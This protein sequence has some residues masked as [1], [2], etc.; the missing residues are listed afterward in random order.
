MEDVESDD[1]ARHWLD[2]S[3]PIREA[4]TTTAEEDAKLIDDHTHFLRDKVRRCYFRYYH[5]HKIIVKRGVIIEEF[6]EHAPRVRVQAVLD[7]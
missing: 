2:P 4:S 7:A 5:K 6:D 1:A 3:E